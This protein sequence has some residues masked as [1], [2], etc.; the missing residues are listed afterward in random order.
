MGSN[1]II[2]YFIGLFIW[3]FNLVFRHLHLQF[4][5]KFKIFGLQKRFNTHKLINMQILIQ[6]QSYIKNILGNSHW[7]KEKSR[8]CYVLYGKK[9][10]QNLK[11][12][13]LFDVDK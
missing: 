2:A 3:A 1:F 13:F 12:V 11:I 7:F 5:T 9:Q 4:R 10:K 6:H 8:F